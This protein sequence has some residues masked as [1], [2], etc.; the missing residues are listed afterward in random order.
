VNPGPQPVVV[1]VNVL[2]AAVAGGNDAFHSWPS[3]PPVRGN[4]AANVVGILNDAREFSLV[5]SEHIL[6]NTVRVLTGA[7]QNGFGWS[8]EPAQRY[9]EI[10]VQIAEA[11]GGTVVEPTAM[12]TDCPDHEDN[13]ILECAQAASATLI[14]SDDDH[15]LQLSPWRGIPIITSTVL[16]ERVDAARRAR[17]E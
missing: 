17:R 9:V 10:L 4:R 3:P 6:V 11:S 8:T 16:V 15:L 1:D 13:R 7:P 5:L 14:V 2:V 12:V